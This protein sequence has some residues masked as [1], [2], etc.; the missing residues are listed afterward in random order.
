MNIL[1]YEWNEFFLL[2]VLN[3]KSGLHVLFGLVIFYRTYLLKNMLHLTCYIY[4]SNQYD[5]S[6]R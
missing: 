3:I 1:R 4:I 6:C 5:Q 2:Y